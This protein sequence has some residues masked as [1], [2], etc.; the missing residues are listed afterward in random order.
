MQCVAFGLILLAAS[1]GVWWLGVYTL[2]GQSYED[3]VWSRFPHVLPAW[4]GP[5]AH[6]FAISLLVQ[7]QRRHGD[8]RID[9]ADCA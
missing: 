5:V 7:G 3:M 6:I 8:H 9:C 2:S 1:V 4:L